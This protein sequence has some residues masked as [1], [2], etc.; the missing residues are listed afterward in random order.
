MRIAAPSGG[1][2]TEQ[3]DEVARLGVEPGYQQKR[4]MRRAGWA[5]RDRGQRQA[6]DCVLQRPRTRAVLWSLVRR[7]AV[8]SVP[9][10]G[11]SAV[12]VAVESDD[13]WLNLPNVGTGTVGQ[14]RAMRSRTHEMR[15]VRFA[16]AGQL[17]AA[18]K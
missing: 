3:A 1:G 16:A 5:A 14:V 17:V 18:F 6:A 13:L 4:A 12:A 11:W 7:C 10:Q 9:T 2:R 15:E 8:W